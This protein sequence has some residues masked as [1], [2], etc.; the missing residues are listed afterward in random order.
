VRFGLVGMALVEMSF[1]FRF[2]WG[3]LAIM[4]GGVPCLWDGG[5]S[6]GF[7]GYQL[8]FFRWPLPCLESLQDVTVV[9]SEDRG[10][11]ED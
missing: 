7:P 11:S 5:F 4:V 9:S 8:S 1:S 2:F 6:I 10:K 3:T